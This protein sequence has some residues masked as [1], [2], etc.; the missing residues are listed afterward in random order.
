MRR[1]AFLDRDGVLL[2]AP[3]RNGKPYVIH[4]V[5]AMDILPGVPEAV[6]ALRG[7]GYMTVV[8]TNQPDVLRGVTTRGTVDAMNGRLQAELGLDAV[9][10]CFHDDA[11]DCDCRKPK[12]GLLF[13]AR[14]AYGLDLARSFMI[15]DRW[16]DVDAGRNAGCRTVFID[17]QYNEPRPQADFVCGSLK[18]A[19]SWILT[20]TPP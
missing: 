3:V 7:A 20:Q 9:L 10:T 19:A 16:R 11:D 17:H 5:A 13:Q 18:E 2:Q 14:E 6:A 8:V 4:D 12:P 1:A 15:G